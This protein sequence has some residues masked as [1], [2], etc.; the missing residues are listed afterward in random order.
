MEKQFHFLILGDFSGRSAQS[1][2]SP[3]VIKLDKYDFHETFERLNVTW[4]PTDDTSSKEQVYRLN[5]KEMDDF[6]PDRLLENG[7]VLKKL[8]SI[9]ERI[10]SE[11]AIKAVDAAKARQIV[12]ECFKAD[13]MPDFDATKTMNSLDGFLQKALEQ[14]DV[15]YNNPKQDALVEEAN[16]VVIDKLLSI[17]HHPKF[18]KLE[19][20]WHE[21]Y[22]LITETETNPQLKF[23]LVDISKEELSADLIQD[24]PVE[25][26]VLFKLLIER[27]I[28]SQGNIPWT[29]MIGNYYF[30]NSQKDIQLLHKIGQMAAQANAPFIGGASPGLVGAP[31]YQ[32]LVDP[33]DWT[34]Q[35]D[36][37]L[38]EMWNNLRKSEEAKF[39]SLMMPRFLL[40]L[41]YSKSTYPCKSVDLEEVADKSSHNSYL[42][43][44]A[45]FLAAVLIGNSFNR[46]GW[47]LNDY[48]A[49]RIERLLLYTYRT[50]NEVVCLPTGEVILPE[51]AGNQI[52]EK[53]IVP[54]YSIPDSDTIVIKGLHSLAERLR[55]G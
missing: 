28:D 21:L 40:R 31:S 25:K 36:P 32:E 3:K 16:Q 39:L 43:G 27:S 46:F 23:S 4:H 9:R 37:Q 35:P 42:W 13:E 15:T 17:L 51:R 26:S 54:I 2:Y 20:A 11:G 53:G 22:F 30:D 18:Q 44:N 1:S 34:T 55:L 24:Q 52:R 41:P 14:H 33:D 29:V 6:H 49:G 47:A 7:P 48:L 45:A 10:K 5:F 8:L 12:E 19:A 38:S 50:N